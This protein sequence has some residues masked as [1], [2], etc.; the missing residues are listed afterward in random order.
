M[1]PDTYMI[2]GDLNFSRYEV[3]ENINFG[4]EQALTIQK[5]VGGKRVIDAMG[6]DDEPL[7]W[8]GMFQGENATARAQYL[9][10]LRIAGKVLT[11]TWGEFAYYVVI[12][13]AVME[14]QRSYQIP[15]TSV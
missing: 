10:Y 14:Y 6:R 4:G 3:P 5:L 12:R 1:T 9:N 15:Y 11:L 7:R 13:S 8:S 2:L